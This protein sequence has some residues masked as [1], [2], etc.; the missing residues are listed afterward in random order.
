MTASSPRV[1]VAMDLSPDRLLY[2][3]SLIKT[4]GATLVYVKDDCQALHEAII[5]PCQVALID[6]ILPG[7]GGIA[8]CRQLINLPAAPVT[9]ILLLNNA[10][11][12]SPAVNPGALHCLAG[13]T[14][15]DTIYLHLRK[16]FPCSRPLASSTL[17]SDTHDKAPLL[18]DSLDV[19]P[20]AIILSNSRHQVIESNAAVSRLT[21]INK[22]KLKQLSLSDVFALLDFNIVTSVILQKLSTEGDWQGEVHA[23]HGNGEM[24]VYWLHALQLS[25]NDPKNPINNVFFLSDITVLIQREHRMRALAET[26]A[27]TGL[28]NRNLFISCLDTAVGTADLHNAPAVL[29]I[30]LD[31]FKAVNDQLGH[32]TGDKLLC[33]V[34]KVLQACVRVNDIVARIG[35]DEFVLLL[36][37]ATHATLVET[38]QRINEHLSFDFLDK[39]NQPIGVTCSIGVAVYPRDGD[40]AKSLLK[41]AD[42]AM[43]T[44]KENGK[45]SFCF[46]SPD[47]DQVLI[48]N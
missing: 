43:Y 15:I 32:G 4:D 3:D 8:L 24:R 12:Q 25:G 10:S 13:V 29:F 21:G 45:N 19:M 40:N 48:G 38:A 16:H 33:D 44:A 20:Y 5:H 11:G 30:D 35:G 2:L 31:G 14:D 1:L 26:D 17:F 27:L 39:K 23:R 41:L 18:N 22:G 42:Q 46:A 28:A 6:E 34:A 7:I 37:G 47:A 9:T 36:I